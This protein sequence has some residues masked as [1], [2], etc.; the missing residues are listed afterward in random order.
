MVNPNVNYGVGVIMM[1]QCNFVNYN[2]YTTLTET[3]IIGEAAHV[4][5]QEAYGK[6]LYLPLNFAVN[7]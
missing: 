1:C 4:W 5:G 3:L 7:L 6:S 2:K